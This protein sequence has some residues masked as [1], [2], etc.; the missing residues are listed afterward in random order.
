MSYIEKRRTALNYEKVSNPELET[1][2]RNEFTD[3]FPEI[4]MPYDVVSRYSMVNV[5]TH[6][7]G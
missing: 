4:R 7:L 6:A 5:K 2:A 3:L 1:D